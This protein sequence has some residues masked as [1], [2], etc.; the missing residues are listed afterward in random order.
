MRDISVVLIGHGSSVDRFAA[1]SIRAA[2]TAIRNKKLFSEVRVGLWKGRPPLKEAVVRA[3]GPIVLLLPWLF[4]EGWFARR[5]IPAAL[6]LRAR[7]TPRCGRLLLYADPVGTHPDMDR[8]ILRCAALALRPARGR[9]PPRRKTELLLVGHGTRR[10][11]RSAGA[12]RAAAVRLR[13]R[14]QWAEVLPAFLDQ[15][16]SVRQALRTVR[17]PHAVV[18]PFLA[19]DGPHARRDLPR[20][21]G[22]LRC[23]RRSRK[24][25]RAEGR[26]AIWC[27]R[28]V[29]SGPWM[30]PIVLKRVR[31]TLR[32][33]RIKTRR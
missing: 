15:A 26:P 14:R 32:R 29:G 5:A 10:D 25:F 11:P 27:A 18:V 23:G 31:E 16:P 2:A 19:D 17:A 13:R 22:L 7:A 21:M 4:S 8:A 28:A 33:F 1:R 6:G 12:V 24:P 3:R 9:P 30:L 20:A